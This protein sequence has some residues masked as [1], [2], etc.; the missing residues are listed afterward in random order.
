M[1]RL[2]LLGVSGLA[3]E[4][5]ELV[6]LVDPALAEDVQMLDQGEEHH[7]LEDGVRVLLAMGYPQV[8][9]RVAR[10]LEAVAPGAWVTLV[11]PT[12]AVSTSARLGAGVVVAAGAIVSTDAQV[13]DHVLVNYGATVGHDAVLGRCCVVNPGAAVSGGV[14][15]HPGVLVGAGAVVLEGR[16]VGP[17]AIVGAGAVVTHDVPAGVTVVGVPARE[18][19][20]SRSER[21]HA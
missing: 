11:H 4:L 18:H 10:S 1:S 16:S 2:V 5:A 21:S 7:A 6:A 20:A 3:R 9:E 13:H 12:A 14:H 8:R 19:P 15:L 17:G